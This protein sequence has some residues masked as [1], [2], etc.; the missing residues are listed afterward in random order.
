MKEGLQPPSVQPPKVHTESFQGT[1]L[2]YWSE[3][4]SVSDMSCFGIGTKFQATPQKT[5]SW[6]LLGFFFKISDE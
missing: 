3:K 5:E 4:T 1:F 6:F 2:G